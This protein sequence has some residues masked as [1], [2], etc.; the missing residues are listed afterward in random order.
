MAS[1]ACAA[2]E[3]AIAGLQ[4]PA[5]W[6]FFAQLTQIPRPSK[7]EARV[8]QYLKDF[9]EARR[10]S[11][12]QD[13]VGNLVICRPGSGGGEAAPGVVIQL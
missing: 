10:L 6:K 7:H 13:A 11:W 12:R 2:T 1:D 8:L 3:A 4:P 9:A 5:L